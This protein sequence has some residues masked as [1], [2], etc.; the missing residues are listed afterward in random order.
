MTQSAHRGERARLR[1]VRNVHQVRL[2]ASVRLGNQ[3]KCAPKRA[4]S[5]TFFSIPAQTAARRAQGTKSIRIMAHYPR[6]TKRREA[7][8]PQSPRFLKRPGQAAGLRKAIEASTE[9]AA[10]LVRGSNARPRSR[11]LPRRTT[12]LNCLRK[13]ES[14]VRTSSPDSWRVQLSSA[15]PWRL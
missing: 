3:G 15:P 1:A 9:S 7:I 14:E 12:A 13:G 10:P 5:A 8:N 6:S 11:T 2:C 4:A